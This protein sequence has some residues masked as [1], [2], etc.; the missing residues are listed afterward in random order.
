MLDYARR[1]MGLIEVSERNGIISIKGF[2]VERLKLDIQKNWRTSKIS[3]NMFI[4]AGGS[5]VTIP[6]FFAIEIIFIL[7][8]LLKS[9]RTNLSKRILNNLIIEITQ[10]TWI[11]RLEEPVKPWMDH[12]AAEGFAFKLLPHQVAF[13]KKY[14]V[15]KPTY[16]LKGMMLFAAPG[17]GKTILDI[18][19]SRAVGATKVI[20]ISPANALHRVWEHTLNN[21]MKVAEH[22]YVS[23]TDGANL[24]PKK[25]YHIFSYERLEYALE[26]VSK[27]NVRSEKITIILDESHNFNRLESLRTER[28]IQ[29]C[30]VSEADD[31]IWASGTPI[32]ALGIESI[33]LLRT[34]D[35][36]FTPEV[37]QSF[38]K[39]YG[40]DAVKTL[41]ILSHRL[42]IVSFVVPKQNVMSDKP[43][44]ET[45]N[46]RLKNGNI[47]TLESIGKD[48]TD[49]I[50]KRSAELYGVR[51]KVA[52]EFFQFLETFQYTHLRD[53]R[54][55]AFREY[56]DAV[57]TLY[58]APKFN[59]AQHAPLAMLTN[60]YEKE[61][62]IP[63][64]VDSKQRAKFISDKS[65]VKYPDLKVRGECLGLVLTKARIACHIDMVDVINFRELIDTAEKKTIVFT[66][67]VK[68]LE[69]CVQHLA[70]LKYKPLAVYGE[71]N[72]D[73]PNIIQR[74]TKDQTLNPLVATFQSLST[75]VPIVIANNIIMLNNPWR[76][77]DREQAIARAHRIGQDKTVTVL[78]II[79]DTDGKPNI[80]SRSLDVM[81]WSKQQVDKIMGMEADNVSLESLIDSS[82]DVADEIVDEII[83]ETELITEKA[84]L[85]EHA[86][87]QPVNENTVNEDEGPNPFFPEQTIEQ[88][89]TTVSIEM[90]NPFM[91]A[92]NE[93]KRRMGAFV[94]KLKERQ[95]KNRR[96][97]EAD[98]DQNLVSNFN[99][100]AAIKAFETKK[101]T[102]SDVSPITVFVPSILNKNASMLD[103]LKHIEASLDIALEIMSIGGQ[104]CLS[105]LNT[106]IGSPQKLQDIIPVT[107]TDRKYT[108]NYLEQHRKEFG[109][110]TNSNNV[111]SERPI[112]AVY[113]RI[114]DYSRAIE[115]TGS[116]ANKR[117]LVIEKL[118]A[119]RD[120]VIVE[121]NKASERL[122]HLINT[123]P[124]VY[125]LGNV[126]GDRLTAICY[127][128][129]EETEFVGATLY[130]SNVAIKA[131]VDTAEK[132]E[133]V[134]K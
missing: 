55:P 109:K 126:A 127:L 11:S 5:S 90:S 38:K 99:S 133:R 81:E 37:E 123:K 28:F 129:A 101:V 68:V 112:S 10:N 122:I 128:F 103:Y 57:K 18:A 77:S 80:S 26:L 94:T 120:Q 19:L 8:E 33:P 69:K 22:P 46:V 32:K 102:Y 108:G 64:I 20:I 50:M 51:E 67:Y 63:T 7:K 98:R 87:N 16:G 71:T 119:F 92:T 30:N 43:V 48:M 24:D 106:Y 52:K 125:K 84:M 78:D 13:L 89:Y 15:V 74:F 70:D 100:D 107:R 61:T 66:S 114:K 117:R 53:A 105:V 116:I 1:A 134:L 47:Y 9:G 91:E 79:L 96:I 27:W 111:S 83:L 118:P 86:I 2:A 62:I 29:L 58:R 75:A 110:L 72:K 21:E 12:N 6:S 35:P 113:P 97:L 76:S 45:V 82:A 93:V 17:S 95:E 44:E 3:S 34:I 59:G 130:N 73:L 42:G 124:D 4:K 56:V 132:L 23:S 14:E 85:D 88:L 104:E 54:D 49:Y 36:L 41:D 131:M 65:I 31:V 25:K 115:I 39:M 121:V 40:R 60:K